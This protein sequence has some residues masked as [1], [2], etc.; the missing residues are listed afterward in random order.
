VLLPG[1]LW[2]QGARALVAAGDDEH[3]RRVLRAGLDWLQET[4]RDHVPESFRASFLHRNP[5][6]RALQALGSRLSVA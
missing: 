3:A 1:E 4:A 2:L 6:N 5:V